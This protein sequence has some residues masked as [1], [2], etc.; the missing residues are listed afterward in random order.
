MKY[1]VC[2]LSVI[3]VRDDKTDASEI[4]TQMLFGETLEVLDQINQW[5]K[6]RVAYDDYIGW[7]DEKQFKYVPDEDFHEL[8]R[9]PQK[10]FSDLTGHVQEGDNVTHIMI[11]SSL[12]FYHEG[13][14]K[15]GET[16]YTVKGN[17]ETGQITDL[18]ERLLFYNKQYLNAPYLWGGRS[19][20]G[21]DCSG[22]TQNTLKLC[23]IKIKRDA[24]DQAEQGETINYSE[25]RAGDVPFFAKNGKVHHVGILLD[26]HT[27][28]HASG[29]VRIDRFDEKGI[30]NEERN[31]YTHELCW[32]KR[33]I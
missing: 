13:E 26:K 10:V 29:C 25:A 7:I 2:H 24:C 6:I 21:V 9:Q 5:V 1:G 19:L 20:F 11:G 17:Y 33:Y 32:I 12:P 3:P 28:I 4:K 15:I 23:N 30:Y 27:I 8:N 31:K 18:T 22:L 16:T 14:I